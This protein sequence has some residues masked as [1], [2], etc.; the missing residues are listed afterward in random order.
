MPELRVGIS[1]WVYP[2]WRGNFYPRGLPQ[3]LELAYA[4]RWFNAL[5]INGTF[6]SLQRPSS[7]QAWYDATPPEFV[8]ALKGGRF[9]THLRRLKEPRQGLANYFASGILRLKEKLGP[10][11]WQ[12]P[13][14][15]SFEE[16]KFQAFC[17]LLPRD[18]KELGRLAKDHAPFLKK[19]VELEPDAVRPIRHAVEFRHESFLTD[20]FIDLMRQHNFAVVIADTASK[21]PS[22]E[23][24]TADWIYV[25]LHGSRQM[26]V[27]GY[28]P[29]EIK[30]WASRIRT[31]HRGAE[32]KDA[33]RIGDRAPRAKTGRDVFTFFD[34]TDVKQ[35]SPVDARGLAIELGIEPP[36]TADEVLK[37]L[38]VKKR[39]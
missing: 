15:L 33:R 16:D 9:V 18:T 12:L 39:K 11:L 24:V 25:R 8:F 22:T 6:Y 29:P 13:P 14:N 3:K 38:G 4:S 23:D 19:R 27:S 2:P 1:G 30:A 34:N 36:L 7:F 35:R 28:T 10:I 21:F 20:R 17:D 37:E 5:E 31:W 32:P 26:Y